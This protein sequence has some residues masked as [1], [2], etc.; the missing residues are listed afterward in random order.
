[1]KNYDLTMKD[2]TKTSGYGMQQIATF[3]NWLSD[4]NYKPTNGTPSF[5]SGLT[6]YHTKEGVYYSTIKLCIEYNDR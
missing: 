4:N 6:D 5:P 2:I 1:M 3:K